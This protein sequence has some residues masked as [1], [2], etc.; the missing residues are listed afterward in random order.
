MNKHLKHIIK[1]L[2]Y[3]APKSIKNFI[4]RKADAKRLEDA[5]KRF[6]RT[7]ITKEQLGAVL[8]QLDWS[9]DVLLH[10]SVINLG[11]VVG[12]AKEI[13]RQVFERFDFDNHTLLIPALPYLG[14]FADYLTEDS[15]FDVRTAPNAMGSVC[16][17][18]TMMPEA[19]RSVH[20]THSVVALG[21]DAEYYTSRH[22]LDT[23]PFG[24]NSPYRTLLQKN[25]NVVLLGAT[26]DNITL[27]HCL[28]D[29]YG[30]D[31]P[32]KRIYSSRRF[33]VNCI[34]AYGKSLLVE[35]PVHHPLTSIRRDDHTTWCKALAEGIVRQISLGEGYVYQFNARNYIKAL[36]DSLQ[37]GRSNYGKVA[38]PKI[39]PD[40][41]ILFN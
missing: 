4:N 34:D 24:P 10:V 28:E 16:E 31:F 18:I 12:G 27:V 23:T 8:D 36:N 19:K 35:T 39:N 32:V 6:K 1:Y 33:H 26:V 30:N 13:V 22:H 29:F 5:T 40:I 3:F 37:C 9:H 17:L 11:R 41:N 21:R 2:R 15:T 38:K 7:K 25:G 14:S 20:P